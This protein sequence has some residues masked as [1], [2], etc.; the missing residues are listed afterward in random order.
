MSEEK[1][2]QACLELFSG[3][4]RAKDV[5]AAARATRDWC[6]AHGARILY[7]GHSE[8]PFDLS[9]VEKLPPF[10][11]VWGESAWLK[12]RCISVIGSREPS[13]L[14]SEWMSVHL[15]EFLRETG[16]VTVSGGARGVDMRTHMTSLR[17][18]L[19]TV[20]FLP[21]GLARL[22]PSEWSHL[23]EQVLA[24]GGAL[25][26]TYAPH[27]DLRRW[28]FEERNRWIA[29]MGALVFVVEARR[30]SGSS[31]TARIARDI[32]RTV[33]ALPGPPGLSY[34]AG[35]LDLLFEGGQPIRDADDLRVL[36]DLSSVASR[37]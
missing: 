34:C 6:R 35:S 16:A 14:A 24:A 13:P 1:E 20:V 19:P 11:S 30:R 5:T 9:S 31:M 3:S 15:A 7:P 2:F 4:K 26:S 28:H 32:G 23:K 33:C 37:F 12:G 21:A 22:Y 8:Y 29:T 18:G 36:F 25:V 17:L 10:L 27:Q